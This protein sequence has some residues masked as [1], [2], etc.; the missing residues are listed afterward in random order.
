MI[1]LQ[2]ELTNSG[3]ISETVKSVRCLMKEL[4]VLYNMDDDEV[5]AF[6][7]RI[8]APYDLLAQ[9]KQMKRFPVLH[10]AAGG[11]VTSA[12]AALLMQLGCNGVFVGSE[13]FDYEDAFN[14]VKGIVQAVKNYNDPHVFVETMMMGLK[15]GDNRIEDESFDTEN[16]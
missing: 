16:V 13:I 8:Q 3:N 1:R 11:I 4:R 6:A 2:G 14:R 15:L 9:T 10:F 7:K 12:D 5:F